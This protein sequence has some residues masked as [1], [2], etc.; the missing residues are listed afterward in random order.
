MKEL[1][2]IRKNEYDENNPISYVDHMLNKEKD[3]DNT[4]SKDG[5]TT[6]DGDINSNVFVRYDASTQKHL[7]LEDIQTSSE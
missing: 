5:D 4:A 7:S 6:K 2:E 1:I 3:G